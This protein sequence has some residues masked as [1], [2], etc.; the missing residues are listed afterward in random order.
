[1][2][3]A[4]SECPLCASKGHR[5]VAGFENHH[6]V[7]CRACGFVYCLQD[8][9][10]EELRAFYRGYPVR[11]VLSPVTA[12][13]FDELLD[14]FE[15]Y[16]KTGR[17]IDVG[18][19]A[20]LFLERAALRGWEVFGTEYGDRAVAACK[21]RGIRIIEGPLDPSNYG[22][23]HFDVVCSFEVIEHL[24]HP[25]QEIA[26]MARILRPGGLLYMTTPNFN[27]M[28]R[29]FS[30]SA[31][32]IVNYPEHLSYFT[33]RTL[34]RLAR[35]A[36]LRQQW[37]LTTGVH[38]WRLRGALGR[39]SASTGNPQDDVLRERIESSTWLKLV[40]ALVNGLLNLFKVGDSMKAGFRKPAQ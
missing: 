21:A 11:D 16:R 28:G 3:S 19:G 39:A 32:S 7:K 25:R 15:P 10:V 37:M 35:S 22:D 18:C 5:S 20:G 9:S 29:L 27:S 13:R 17:L 6:L 23:D 26:R 1:M 31:W 12:L 38:L 24:A 2:S 14:R 40:K 33:P 8:P 34:R 4:H 36:G 30:R